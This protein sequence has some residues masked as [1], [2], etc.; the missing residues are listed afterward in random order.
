M[1]VGDFDIPDVVAQDM[2]RQRNLH[3]RPNSD[4]M[5]PWMNGSDITGH[6]RGMWIIDFEERDLEEASLYEAPF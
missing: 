1:K 5:K 6:P 2:L 4:V 3:G